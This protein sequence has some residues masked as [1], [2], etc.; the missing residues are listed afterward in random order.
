MTAFLRRHRQYDGFDTLEGVIV[1]VDVFQRL[2]DAGNHRGKI[3]D[4]THLLDLLDL[5]VEVVEVELVL[6][7]FL[8][9]PA[10]FLLVVLLLSALHEAD[11]VAHTEDTVGHTRGVEGVYGFHL[12]ARAYKLYRLVDNGANR[13]GSTAARVAVELSEDNAGVVE[14]VVEL[15]GRVDGVLTRHGIDHKERLIRVDSC[16]NG[17][18]LLH[19]LLVDGQ[20]AGGVDDDGVVAL[21]LGLVDCV[22]G[23]LH[24]VLRLQFH[25]Y[26]HFYLLAQHP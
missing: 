10:G 7:D 16:L 20:T 2:A 8:L 4:V 1:D 15:L 21:S 11:D 23:Y 22:Q 17:C 12:L 26:G 3:L 19:Q 6:T 14:A 13:Q 9:Q 25:I 5:G 24:G 18:Y